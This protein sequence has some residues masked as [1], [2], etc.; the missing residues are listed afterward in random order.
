MGAA[1]VCA[2]ENDMIEEKEIVYFSVSAIAK[3]W[4]CSANKVISVLEEHRGEK[5]FMDLGS[6]ENLRTHKRRYSIIRVHPALL[7]TIESNL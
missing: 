7:N 1:P 6:P 5:G 4:N 2:A 3:R